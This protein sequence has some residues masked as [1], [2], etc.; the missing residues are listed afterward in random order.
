MAQHIGR[1]VTMMGVLITEKIVHTKQGDPM[2]FVSFEDLTGLY[3]AT[4]FP[5]VYRQTCHLLAPNHAYVIQGVVEAHFAVVTLTVTTIRRAPHRRVP[6]P[7][8][9]STGPPIW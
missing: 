7:T 4:I 9:S 5:A 8:F 6:Q 2:E 1:S 3:D